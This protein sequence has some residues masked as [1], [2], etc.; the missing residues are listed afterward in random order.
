MAW[1]GIGHGAVRFQAFPGGHF[2]VFVRSGEVV[3]TL[4]EIAADVWRRR[5][6][7]SD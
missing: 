1:A 5:E 4:A 3:A 2:Y 7:C 6:P